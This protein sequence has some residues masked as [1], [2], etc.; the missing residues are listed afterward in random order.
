MYVHREP[1]DIGF[2][3]LSEAERTAALYSLLQHS[4]PVQIRFFLSVL[5]HM[6]QS[7]P[8]AA[9][10]SPNPNQAQMDQRLSALRPEDRN[11][12]KQNRISAPGTLVPHERWQGQLDQV[13]ERGNSP[14]PDRRSPTPEMR[15]KSH[16]YEAQPSPRPT[17]SPMASWASMTNTP[18]VPSFTDPKLDQFA[19]L[20]LNNVDGRFRRR[21]VSGHYNDDGEFVESGQQPGRASPQP[22]PRSPVID[23][24]GLGG[25]G[26]GADPHLA[27]LG[28][29]G[30][31]QLLALAQAQAQQL[32]TAA[33][34]A[35][36]GFGGRYDGLARRSPMLKPTSPTP[37]RP[38]GGG[39]GGGA[40]VA[41]PDDVDPKTI[42]DVT[43]WLR[44]LRLHVS[45]KK[46]SLTAEIHGQL[47]Q[48]ILEGHGQHE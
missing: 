48:I 34:F 3:V 18:L 6:A 46:V 15:P 25:L 33:S 45:A 32:S 20:S 47:C 24:Y 26:I 14:D 8:M 36:S 39:A 38:A 27:G 12:L 31:A 30:N 43:N 16:H 41:G 28:M 21:N 29:S 4:T 7:D 23:Q 17:N 2:R 37:D 5:Q 44:V 9:L 13:A 19:N 1:A 22:W 40:G 42:S 11:K 10:L 35:Q